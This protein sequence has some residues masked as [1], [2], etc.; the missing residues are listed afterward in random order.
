MVIAYRN[1]FGEALTFWLGFVLQEMAG[2][3][4]E[5]SDPLAGHIISTTIGGKNGEPKRVGVTAYFWSSIILEHIV[6]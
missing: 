5:G 6:L 3:M 4:I 2:S 1:H